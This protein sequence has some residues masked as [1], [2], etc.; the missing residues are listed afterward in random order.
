MSGR[1][2]V[3]GAFGFLGWHLTCRLAA[4]RNL[5]PVRLGRHD[6]ADRAVLADRLTDI[7]TVIHVAGVNRADTDDEVELG[8]AEIA[9][10]LADALDGRPVHLVYADSIHAAADSAYG[11]GKR[12]ARE[13]LADA[14]GTLADVVLPNLFGEHGRPGYNSFVATFCHTIAAG[15][16]PSIDRDR[17]V[18]LLHVQAAA[19]VL[20]RAA[21]QREDRE[22]RPRGEEHTVSHV[23]E[24]LQEFHRLYAGRGEVPDLSTPFARNLFNTYRACLFPHA[25]PLYPEVHADARGVLVETMRSHGGTGQSFASTTASGATRGNHYHLHKIERFAVV[26]GQA[27]I[28]LRRLYHDEVV[29]FRVS[30]DKPAIVDMPTLWVHNIRNVGTEDVVTV[31]WTDELLDPQ[32]PDQYPSS[33]EVES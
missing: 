15:G 26:Q 2:A 19:E 1:I 30:G 7:D 16:Q 13:I 8:N 28:A 12:R 31:F 18:P 24:M 33:V 5:E 22:V 23:L 29:R 14:P 17:P 21:E 11:R 25:Y 6:F 32:Q 3:T 4:T 10:V 20:I 9:S 27:E